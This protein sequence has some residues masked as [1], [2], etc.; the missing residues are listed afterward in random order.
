MKKLDDQ[1]II[2]TLEEKDIYSVHD[3]DHDAKLNAIKEHYDFTISESWVSPSFMFYTETTADGYE[4][5]I[6]TDD[7]RILI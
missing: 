1:L 6:A 3:L 7:D 5:W 4:V 2:N